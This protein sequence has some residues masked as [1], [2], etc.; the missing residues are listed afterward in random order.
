VPSGALVSVIASIAA[1]V[2]LSVLF[3][4]VGRAA[5]D[6]PAGPRELVFSDLMIWAG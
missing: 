4:A 3:A 2:G 6:A 1:A 5:V